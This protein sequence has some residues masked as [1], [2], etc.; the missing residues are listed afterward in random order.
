MITQSRKSAYTLY[1]GLPINDNYSLQKNYLN[2]AYNVLQSCL[3]DYSKIFVVSVTLKFPASSLES[4]EIAEGAVKRF[5]DS[6]RA[7]LDHFDIQ[8]RKIH[9]YRTNKVRFIRATEFGRQNG[10]M[11]QDLGQS[12]A[13]YHL[14]LLFNGHVF[15]TL[16]QYY[17]PFTKESYSSNLAGRITKAW[18]SA[19]GISINETYGLVHF[20]HS[21]YFQKTDMEKIMDTFFHISYLCKQETKINSYGMGF[22]SFSCSRS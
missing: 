17:I 6:L 11:S 9:L 3:R 1:K 4:L 18:S 14:A 16:G 2:A 8:Q 21:H 20:G 19:L 10:Q 12:R 13:H 5:I 7:Q 22:K 15:N